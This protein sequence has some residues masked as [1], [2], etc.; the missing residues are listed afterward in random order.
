MRLDVLG[1]MEAA[2]ALG[3]DKLQSAWEA[4]SQFKKRYMEHK[5]ELDVIRLGA[6][7]M[8]ARQ[9]LAS[10]SSLPHHP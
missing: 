6:A 9:F 1:R 10:M 7:R 4:A 5:A 8:Q 3:D 2:G